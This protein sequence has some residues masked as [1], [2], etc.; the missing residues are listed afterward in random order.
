MADPIHSPMESL[1][2]DPFLVLDDLCIRTITSFLTP[3]DLV[4][5]SGVSHLWRATM[6]YAVP[7]KVFQQCYPLWEGEF[8]KSG[9]WKDF[10][11]YAYREFAIPRGLAA[12][13]RRLPE[14]YLWDSAG[15]YVVWCS[16]RKNILNWIV[17]EPGGEVSRQAMLMKDGIDPEPVWP[18]SPRW[19]A[20]SLMVNKDGLVFMHDESLNCAS[21]RY[22]VYSLPERRHIWSHDLDPMAD[23]NEQPI[24]LGKDRLYI[25]QGRTAPRLLPPSPTVPLFSMLNRS[26]TY[27][28]PHP[29]APPPSPTF[30]PVT[31]SSTPTLQALSICT[32]DL[33]YAADIPQDLVSSAFYRLLSVGDQEFL[34]CFTDHTITSSARDIAIMDG[35]TGSIIQWIGQD[36]LSGFRVMAAPGASNGFLVWSR[37]Q[38]VLHI[39]WATR[40]ATNTLDSTV[41][42]QQTF[43]RLVDG[44]FVRANITTLEHAGSG[45][46]ICPGSSHGLLVDRHGYMSTFS[47]ERSKN[48][49]RAIAGSNGEIYRIDNEYRIDPKS[50]KFAT[51]P[52]LQTSASRLPCRVGSS[53]MRLGFMLALGEGRFLFDNSDN[54]EEALHVFDFGPGW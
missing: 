26:Y 33:I 36:G 17:M 35:A 21:V 13:M 48:P 27:S 52:P 18:E 51:L 42:I 37:P 43:S 8:E 19:G 31:I 5:C 54:P 20:V 12:W 38:D 34:I 44:T 23:N 11:R 6:Q 1:P 45:F 9:T 2:H 30:T 3:R 15:Q 49:R 16:A 39:P 24:L 40:P 7:L 47:V 41:I 53:G 22:V 46:H 14:A 4:R 50:L 28:P 29:P 32:R 10:V 25:V